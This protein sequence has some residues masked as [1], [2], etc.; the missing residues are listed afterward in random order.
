SG[1]LHL[2]NGDVLRVNY[3]ASNGLPYTS[4][5]RYL[6]D[7]KMI[8]SGSS[9]SIQ[10]FL[11]GNPTVRNDVMFRNRRYIF[12]R[13]VKL[14]DNE[15]PIGS[16]GVPLIAGRSVAADQ[17]YVPAGAV[18]YIKTDAPVVGVGGQLV[19]WNKIARFA[20]NHDSGAAIKG[21]GR[22][23]IYWGQGSAAGAAA[24]YM[25]N[26]GDMVVLMCGVEPTR[27]AKAAPSTSEPFERVSW[28]EV[29][30]VLASSGGS[31]L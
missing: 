16:L 28:P 21:P 9:D 1:R 11:R 20:F 2:D 14:K 8:T 29:A 13:E 26:P 30:R 19:G 4:V 23:D 24:G 27:Q 25:H 18:M 7:R 12:F 22:A 17:R 10:D 15:G 6:L 5:G 31:G 3:A